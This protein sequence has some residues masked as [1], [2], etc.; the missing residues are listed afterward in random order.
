MAAL[1]VAMSIMAV[2]MGAALPSWTHL[3]QREREEEY[4][5]RAKQYARAIRMWQDRNNVANVPAPSVDLLVEQRFL[6][7]KYKDPITGDDFV[8]IQTIPGAQRPGFSQQPGLP[9]SPMPGQPPQQGQ[10]PQQ[11]QSPQPG[12]QPLPGQSA[13][14]GGTSGGFIGV[15]SKSKAKGIKLFKGQ[16]TTHDQ[17]AMTYMD[18]PSPMG[19]TAQP[20]QGPGTTGPS[21]GLSG[22]FAPG[23]GN[24]TFN[25]AGGGGFGQPMQPQGGFPTGGFRPGGFGQPVQPPPGGSP[26]QSPPGGSPFQPPPGGFGQQPTPKFPAVPSGMGQPNPFRPPGSQPPPR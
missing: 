1:L 23:G 5:F 21:T 22:P 20:V 24:P 2:L 3:V 17:W 25:P 15:T 12:Q 6:R 10:L 7:K 8:L 4:L 18:V 26:F 16:A 13:R 11:G 19:R 9:S 14:P